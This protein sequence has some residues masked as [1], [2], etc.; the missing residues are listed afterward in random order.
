MRTLGWF[1]CKIKGKHKRGKPLSTGSSD[2]V[3]VHKTFE[4]PRCG[5]RW[6]RK[7]RPANASQ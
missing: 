6:K 4:C 1:I 3:N 2:G 5:E 7:I